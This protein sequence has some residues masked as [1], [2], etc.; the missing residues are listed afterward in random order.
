MEKSIR[1]QLFYTARQMNIMKTITHRILPSVWILA[2]GLILPA[3]HSQA[4]RPNALP[5]PDTETIYCVSHV[6]PG[7]E[8]AYALLRAK[9]WAIY[10]RLGLVLPKPH[11]AARGTDEYGKTYFVEIFTWRDSSIPD[12]AP[13]EVRAIWR[14]LEGA[15]EARAGRPGMDFSDGGITVL[16]V[17]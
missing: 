11:L 12:H 13:A 7:K 4:E 2:I 1:P 3:A 10:R 8:A 15:C 9:A 14:E 6:I 16:E 5:G 17:D